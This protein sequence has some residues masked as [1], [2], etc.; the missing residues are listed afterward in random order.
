MIRQ[1]CLEVN[2][3]IPDD[4]GLDPSA[5]ASETSPSTCARAQKA[6]WSAAA[7][8]PIQLSTMKKSMLM[9]KVTMMGRWMNQSRLVEGNASKP[10][11]TT[12]LQ[13]ARKSTLMMMMASPLKKMLAM[14][15]I[16][17]ITTMKKRLQSTES[18]SADAT[19]SL[20][21]VAVPVEPPVRQRTE[22]KRDAR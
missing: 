10:T 12:T 3:N 5:G 19:I 18:L 7:Q 4:V 16:M 1:S 15:I 17:T 21:L 9:V 20:A 6:D 22:T 14:M 13:T 11:K 2:C 8:C